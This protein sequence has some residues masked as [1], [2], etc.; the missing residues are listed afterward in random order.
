MV[1]PVTRYAKSSDV[2]IAYQVFGVGPI[3]LV[4]SRASYRTLS[5]IGIIL[6]WLAGSFALG[7]SLG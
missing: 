7:A 3:D 4:L 1:L 5:T 2:H 6:I